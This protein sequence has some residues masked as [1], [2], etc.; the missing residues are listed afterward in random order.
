MLPSII[1]ITRRM[2]SWDG[3]PWGNTRNRFSHPAPF[4]RPRHDCRQGYHHDIRRQVFRIGLKPLVFYAFQLLPQ[5]YQRVY[6]NLFDDGE[7][8]FSRHLLDFDNFRAFFHH[9][10]PPKREHITWRGVQGN[11]YAF[12]RI[13]A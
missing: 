13:N 1:D 7:A 6:A 10:G 9:V 5:L 2:V 3:I 11:F 12:I 4:V 8:G